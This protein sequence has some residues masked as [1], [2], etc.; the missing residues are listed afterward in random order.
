MRLNDFLPSYLGILLDSFVSATR[1]IRERIEDNDYKVSQTVPVEN[2]YYGIL[3]RDKDLTK[4]FEEKES[5]YFESDDTYNII[6]QKID[7][8]RKV[9]KY[10][11]I[12]VYTLKMKLPFIVMLLGSTHVN[13]FQI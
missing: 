7:V 12:I 6:T 11:V 9:T 13:L 10:V 4:C 1:Q 8:G 5:G 3:V 2:R